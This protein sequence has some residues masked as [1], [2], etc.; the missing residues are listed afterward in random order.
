MTATPCVHRDYD[1]GL[2]V[3]LLWFLFHG[4][5]II[6]HKNTATQVYNSFFYTK[7][8]SILVALPFVNLNRPRKNWNPEIIK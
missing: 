1:A 8:K 5:A 6:H 7:C 3:L 4:R 2:D